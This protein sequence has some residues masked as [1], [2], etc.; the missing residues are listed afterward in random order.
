MGLISITIRYRHPTGLLNLYKMSY[1]T[2]VGEHWTPKTHVMGLPSLVR[3][4]VTQVNPYTLV[5]TCNL[6][7]ELA[8]SAMVWWSHRVLVSE[9][10]A[11]SQHVA[12]TFGPPCSSI[13]KNRQT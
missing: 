5:Q 11:P 3:P 4:W 9:F 6:A 1:P 2:W 7:A 13:I 12:Y 8:R 10:L